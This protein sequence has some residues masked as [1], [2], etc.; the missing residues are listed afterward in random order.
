MTSKPRYVL[1]I[2]AHGGVP[3]E[4]TD[5][6]RRSTINQLYKSLVSKNDQGK[7]KYKLTRF[8]IPNGCNINIVETAPIGLNVFFE[9]IKEMQ[10]VYQSVYK[11]VMDVIQ[12]DTTD[13][14]NAFSEKINREIQTVFNLSEKINAKYKNAIDGLSKTAIKTYNEYQELANVL[15]EEDENI[16][17][18]KPSMFDDSQRE[19]LN[20]KLDNYNKRFSNGKIAK[21]FSKVKPSEYIFHRLVKY[22]KSLRMP[23]NNYSFDS[24]NEKYP[25]FKLIKMDGVIT[26]IDLTPSFIKH[27]S[28]GNMVHINTKQIIKYIKE[29]LNHNN[30]NFELLILDYSC[31]VGIGLQTTNVFGQKPDY[32]EKRSNSIGREREYEFHKKHRPIWN[33]VSTR[34]F[35]TQSN[36][37]STRKKSTST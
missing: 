26:E 18:G 25:N 1:C 31:S 22:G 5:I 27:F 34:R 35:Y 17:L 16:R 30:S 24:E 7:Y 28:V 33:N 36:R 2:Y 13:D 12:T 4:Q 20:K 15:I 11:K 32:F 6:K 8:D 21:F 19:N 14:F 23:F 9:D 37:N 10:D 3:V 29:K